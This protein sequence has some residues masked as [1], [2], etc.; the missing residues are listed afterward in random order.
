MRLIKTIVYDIN[1]CGQFDEAVNRAI[2][3][4]WDL[5]KVETVQAAEGY[6]RIM[7]AHMEKEVKEEK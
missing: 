2:E 3:D 1:R 6:G 7:V 5:V 4:G